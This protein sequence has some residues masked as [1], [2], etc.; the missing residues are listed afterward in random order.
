[1]YGINTKTKSVQYDIF[2]LRENSNVFKN[3]NFTVD[4]AYLKEYTARMKTKILTVSFNA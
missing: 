3:S 1:M 2:V 4:G